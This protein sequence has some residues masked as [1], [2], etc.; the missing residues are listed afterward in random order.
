MVE[1]VL[2]KDQVSVRFTVL[3]PV[4]A[5]GITSACVGRDARRKMPQRSTASVSCQ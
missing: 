4:L 5:S 2:G 1:R 3:A